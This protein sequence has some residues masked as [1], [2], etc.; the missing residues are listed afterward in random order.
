MKKAPE[1]FRTISEVADILDTP[2]HVLRFWESKFYQIRPVKRAGG[3]RYYRPDDV[4]LINGIKALLQS[5]GMTIRGVQRVLQEQGVKHVAGLGGPLREL[6]P[7]TAGEDE[8]FD[9]SEDLEDP[10]I[11][12]AEIVSDPPLSDRIP[13]PAT[14]PVTA[15][16]APVEDEPVALTPE[17]VLAEARARPAE[18]GLPEEPPLGTLTEDEIEPAEALDLAPESAADILPEGLEEAPESPAV[19]PAPEP[20]AANAEPVPETPPAPA[21]QPAPGI[22][23]MEPSE[24]AML[25]RRLRGMARGGLGPRRDRAEMLARR[26][27]A[28]LERMSEASGAGRW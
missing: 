8:D 24:R 10:A 6:E 5:Q 13:A 19:A 20:V 23:A 14:R 12:E 1:A 27:D 21:A 17:P 2:A 18:A 26:I 11:D 9:L 25:A 4:A 3:R 15:T 22:E 28:L 16:L 7:V